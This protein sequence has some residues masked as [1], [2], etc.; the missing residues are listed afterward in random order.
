MRLAQILA[1]YFFGFL[2]LYGLLAFAEGAIRGEWAFS[3]HDVA[4]QMGAYI[5][6]WGGWLVVSSVF[7]APLLWLPLAWMERRPKSTRAVGVGALFGPI[8]VFLGALAVP[9]GSALI[10]GTA[11]VPGMLLFYPVALLVAGLAFGWAASALD[12]RGLQKS[13]PAAA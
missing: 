6:F 12:R 1:L 10:E 9:G 3:G 13:S 7:I 2:P 5:A 4:Y 8:A 11:F